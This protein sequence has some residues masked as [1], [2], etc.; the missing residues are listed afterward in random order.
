M[1]L[2]FLPDTHGRTVVSEAAREQTKRGRSC[3]NYC[4]ILSIL[5]V[6]IDLEGVHKAFHGY[7]VVWQE[8]WQFRMRYL[9]ISSKFKACHSKNSRLLRAKRDVNG[10][11]WNT[12]GGGG[13]SRRRID[14][15]R[16]LLLV[17]RFARSGGRSPL[18]A[19]F[20]LGWPGR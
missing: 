4:S 11:M 16:G 20:F 10:R 15:R 17:A 2:R 5:S 12:G 8:L 1:P 9:N 14:R 19:A 7:Y 6:S 18:I 3:T 13:L